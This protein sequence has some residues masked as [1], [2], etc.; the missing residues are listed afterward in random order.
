MKNITE[1]TN[2]FFQEHAN[3]FWYLVSIYYPFSNTELA[4]Y[5][6]YVYWGSSCFGETSVGLHDYIDIGLNCNDNLAECDF[7]DECFEKSIWNDGY[8]PRD[9]YSG[10]GSYDALSY[11]HTEICSR[12][13]LNSEG[14]SQKIN[15]NAYNHVE[16]EVEKKYH[17][18]LVIH[19]KEGIFQIIHMLQQEIEKVKGEIPEFDVNG[20]ELEASEL[21]LREFLLFNPLI[22]EKNFRKI[23]DQEFMENANMIEPTWINKH[24]LPF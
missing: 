1:I 12:L 18:M 13:P 7:A 3:M 4:I 19:G 9:F 2:L 8:I 16:I 21:E 11:M 5:R 17:D 6:D 14:G 10:A 24:K 23:I 15:E 20:S 22:W